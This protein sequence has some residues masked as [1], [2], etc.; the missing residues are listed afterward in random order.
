[1]ANQDFDV[2]VDIRLQHQLL[3][4][5]PNCSKIWISLSFYNLYSWSIYIHIYIYIYCLFIILKITLYCWSIIVWYF[6]DFFYC[7]IYFY[8]FLLFIHSFFF[9][10]FNIKVFSLLHWCTLS[11]FFQNCMT[12]NFSSNSS[13]YDRLSFF[14][15]WTHK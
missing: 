5:Y 7:I 1:M 9:C 2:V 8:L 4:F 15:L 6:A 3:R 13:I 14:V 12:W 10:L 11:S